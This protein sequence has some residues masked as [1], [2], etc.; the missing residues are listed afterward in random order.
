VEG[1]GGRCHYCWQGRAGRLQ[2]VAAGHMNPDPDARQK[3]HLQQRRAKQK[4]KGHKGQGP[5]PRRPAASLPAVVAGRALQPSMWVTGYW[6]STSCWLLLL[7]QLPKLRPAGAGC[8]LRGGVGG[9]G[10]WWLLW[11]RR[12]ALAMWAV[13]V[14]PRVRVLPRGA[15]RNKTRFRFFIFAL[16]CNKEHNKTQDSNAHRRW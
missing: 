8:W 2:E 3:A 11:P 6:L 7:V 4:N 1:G 10:P 13:A 12:L 16:F 15:G 14:A 5:R 9:A